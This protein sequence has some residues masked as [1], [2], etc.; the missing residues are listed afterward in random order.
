M[1]SPEN[2]HTSNIIQTEPVI[3]RNMQLNT[4]THT[5]TYLTTI[6]KGHK[7]EREQGGV[8][9]RSWNEKREGRKYVLI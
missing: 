7:Y 4:N 9:R 2:I 6:L 5:N 3:F 8:Y 1:V